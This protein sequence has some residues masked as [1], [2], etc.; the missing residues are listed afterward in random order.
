MQG[1]RHA[2][3]GAATG[4]ISVVLIFIGFAIYGTDIPDASA[5]ANEWGSFFRDHQDRI[6]TSMVLLSLGTFFF[7][8]FLGSLHSAIAAA[9]AAGGR[10]ETIAVAGGVVAAI[11]FIIA[12]SASATAAFRPDEVDPQLTRA[13]ND[14]G[15]LAAAP[16]AAGVAA[17]FGAVAIAGYRHGAFPAPVAGL[18]ALAAI[19]Q[20]FAMLTVT[21]DTGALA[22]DG[23]LGLWVPF[24]PILLAIVATSVTLMR[25]AGAAAVPPPA[26]PQ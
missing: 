26:G 2:R 3:Y 9:E 13:L 25:Q 19:V 18:S 4:I 22:P 8:W 5:S 6:Q 7:L 16:T 11:F 1:D 24:V 20:V 12:V 17:L 21:T 10:L 14:F 23:W 15:V